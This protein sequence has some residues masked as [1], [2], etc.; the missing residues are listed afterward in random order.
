MYRIEYEYATRVQYLLS[1]K[2][3]VVAATG[4]QTARPQTENGREDR[5]EMGRARR[6]K[7]F[8]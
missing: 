8:E 3:G 5:T 7:A 1:L 4:E 6:G 2:T